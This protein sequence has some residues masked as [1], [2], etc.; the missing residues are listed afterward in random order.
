[1]LGFILDFKIK[2][3]K[4]NIKQHEES[5]EHARTKMNEKEKELKTITLIL[6]LT[7]G[8]SEEEKKDLNAKKAKLIKSIESLTNCIA[9]SRK[10]IKEWEKEIKENKDKHEK[11]HGKAAASKA[12]RLKSLYNTN[13]GHVL[14]KDVLYDGRMRTDGITAQFIKVLKSENK[15]KII[16][17]DYGRDDTKD[18]KDI[19][20]QIDAMLAVGKA[21]IANDPGIKNLIHAKVRENSE[22][23]REYTYPQK[24]KAHRDT[25][26]KALR[27]KANLKLKNAKTKLK[28]PSRSEQATTRKQASKSKRKWRRNKKKSISGPKKQEILISNHNVNGEFNLTTKEYYA[29]M[30][31][32]DLT[33]FIKR[34]YKRLEIAQKNIELMNYRKKATNVEKYNE[35]ASACLQQYEFRLT[36]VLNRTSIRKF[37]F[38][39]SQKQQR[40]IHQIAKMLTFGIENPQEN[41][42]IVC[43]GRW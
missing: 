11:R 31:H 17:R 27:R 40:A 35:Y 24:K 26:K 30:G 21:V 5:A 34:E 4:S 23:L 9:E 1:M 2:H 14:A 41:C 22:D 36:H 6:A 13:P 8:K 32:K 33:E 28:Q 39:C 37:K 7:L 43:L 20:D 19:K 10:W 12:D 29:I 38:T 16:V 3:L 18:H 15:E 25:K 42:L